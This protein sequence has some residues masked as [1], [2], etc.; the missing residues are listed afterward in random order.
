M[1]VEN[2]TVKVELGPRAQRLRQL[3][4]GSSRANRARS[5]QASSGVNPRHGPRWVRGGGHAHVHGALPESRF[6]IRG[7]RAPNQL[8]QTAGSLLRHRHQH[9]QPH[10]PDA[11]AGLGGI[12]IRP[13]VRSRLG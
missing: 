8:H 10:T 13:P 9:G 2:I 1:E 7:R 4:T 6:Q 3:R 12:R 11:T 5:V